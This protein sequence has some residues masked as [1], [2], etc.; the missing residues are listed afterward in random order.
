[1]YSDIA[2][3]ST[4]DFAIIKELLTNL[5]KGAELTQSYVENVGRWKDMLTHIP[6]YQ[7]NSDGAIKEWMHP[8]FRDNYEHRHQSHVYPIFPGTEVTRYNNSGLYKGF[9]NAMQKRKVVGLKDQSGWSLAYMSNVFARMGKGDV[10]LE[11]LD[12][13]S[14]SNIMN[15]FLTVHND[16][17]RMGIAVCGDFRDAP[18]QI[19]ANMGFTATIQEMA[20]FSTDSEIYAFNAIPDRWQKGTIGPLLARTN[21]EVTL[22]WDRVSKSAKVYIKQMNTAKKFNI[23]LPE[24]ENFASNGLNM[25]EV[26]LKPGDDV[27][28]DV[29]V[30]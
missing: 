26:S 20:I 17:R 27:V 2:I 29:K 7:L 21:S 15:N 25:T 18:V 3:N 19:D 24:N 4:M 22:S 6:P 8:Y 1:L 14:R 10:A 12:F 11:C 30:K 16:W 9:E 13:L 23:I 28:F 5:I